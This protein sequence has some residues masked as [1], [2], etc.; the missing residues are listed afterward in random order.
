M[1]LEC[2]KITE[3]AVLVDEGILI[4]F[5]SSSFSHKAGSGNI[6]HVNLSPLSRIFHLFIRFWNVFGI[7]QFNRLPVNAAKELVQ[8]GDE[9]GV[10]PLAQLH[11]EHYQTRMGIPAAHIPDQLDLSFGMLVWMAVRPT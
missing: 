1:L 5:L 11:P 7:G 10:S 3:S 8:P 6:F 2:F 9:S 4:V